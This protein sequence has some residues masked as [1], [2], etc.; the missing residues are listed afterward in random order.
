MAAEHPQVS[1]PRAETSTDPQLPEYYQQIGVTQLLEEFKNLDGR[2]NFELFERA[3]GNPKTRNFV[4]D[5]GDEEA[6]CGFDLAVD[7]FNGLLE[8]KINFLRPPLSL[9]LD[10]REITLGLPP[11]A[12]VTD[13]TA[14]TG[15]TQYTMDLYAQSDVFEALAKYYD[16]SP[17]LLAL[18]CS[19]PRKPKP[20]A[21]PK[22]S[23]SLFRRS[24]PR[25]EKSPVPSLDLEEGSDTTELSSLSELDPL[26]NI[27]HYSIVD[28][29]WH[30]SSVDWGRRCM[31]PSLV[32]W[33]FRD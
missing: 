1:A 5:F 29:V 11:D 26:Y 17:R 22:S 12:A 14:A 13:P 25:Q 6:W 18:M 2:V 7:A 4:V 30:Y 16:L 15:R 33:N 24:P 31:F 32:S 23:S 21:A 27:N 9:L 28:D 8:A 3:V 19:D 10:E 20:A